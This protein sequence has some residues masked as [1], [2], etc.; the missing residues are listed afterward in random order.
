[1]QIRTAVPA[2]RGV[3]DRLWLM[4]RHDLS[5]FSGTLPFPDGSFRSERVDSAFGE[6][7]WAPYLLLLDDR[8]IGLSFIRGLDGP[9]AIMN[10]FFIT[11]ATRR[12]GLGLTAA[13]TLISHHPGP[14]QI[15]FQDTNPT[16]APFWRR[17]ATEVAGEAWTEEHRA[18][19]G[20]PDLTP[21]TWIS[22][23]TGSGTGGR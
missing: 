15:P 6:P 5:E 3:V 16:A 4:F 21:D 18:V 19:P 12:R 2:D 9:S 13:R 17:V 14:W 7:G 23:D 1:M 11:R 8:P 10:T 20:R 22:F